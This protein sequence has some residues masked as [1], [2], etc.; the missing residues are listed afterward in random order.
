MSCSHTSVDNCGASE[1]AGV[2]CDHITLVGGSTTNEGNV[3]VNGKP[4]C[5]DAWDDT[6]ALVTCRTLG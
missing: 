5:D 6:D 2:I 3:F 4:V 1:G